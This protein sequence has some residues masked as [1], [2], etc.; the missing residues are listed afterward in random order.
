[1]HFT[2]CYN[3]IALETVGK[4][5]K[6]ESFVIGKTDASVRMKTRKFCVRSFVYTFPALR[7]RQRFICRHAS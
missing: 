6:L 3:Q 1:M 7:V 2:F 5:I 4:H